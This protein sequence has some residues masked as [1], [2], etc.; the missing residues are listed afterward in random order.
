MSQ[1]SDASYQHPR[2]TICLCWQRSLVCFR[3]RPEWSSR[4]HFGGG[5]ASDAGRNFGQQI[6]WR[7]IRLDAECSYGRNRH[8]SSFYSSDYWN[9]CNYHHGCWRLVGLQGWCRQRPGHV[10]CIRPQSGRR[11]RRDIVMDREQAGGGSLPLVDQNVAR[12]GTG[13]KHKS[14]PA[15]RG[16]VPIV[17][18]AP[19]AH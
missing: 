11:G 1:K 13:E 2:C 6:S 4:P 16:R 7:D 15:R 17:Q 12:R 3:L 18:R 10:R 14:W 8:S 19:Q 5:L 9:R